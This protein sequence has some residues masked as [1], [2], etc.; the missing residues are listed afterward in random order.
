MCFGI[1]TLFSCGSD[2]EILSQFSKRKYLKNFKSKTVKFDKQ[3]TKNDIEIESVVKYKEF[4]SSNIEFHDILQ[5]EKDNKINLQIFL[6]EED[7]TKGKGLVLEND[8][9]KKKSQVKKKKKSDSKKEK[10]KK[11]KKTLEGKDNGKSKKDKGIELKNDTTKNKSQVKKKNKT[12][13]KKEKKKKS[14]KTPEE[15][16][17]E[18][19]TKAKE[20]ASENEIR[21]G[22]EKPVTLWSILISIGTGLLQIYFAGF[23]FGLVALGTIISN[24]NRF[25]EPKWTRVLEIFT[26]V[27]TVLMLVL[28]IVL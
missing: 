14:K 21:T 9:T 16:D 26:I 1:L 19:S 4:V 20:L 10:K 18:K 27:W 22:P 12:D 6:I 3:I 7:S 24:P 25:N 11:S 28:I 23:V 5:S 2:S 8:T 17:A 13:N 15:K